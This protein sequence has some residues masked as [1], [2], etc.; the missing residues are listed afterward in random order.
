MLMV[1]WVQ[2]TLMPIHG[3]MGIIA[4][5]ERW[6][7]VFW[8]KLIMKHHSKSTLSQ[9]EFPENVNID[10]EAPVWH[11]SCHTRVELL[12]SYLHLPI[13]VALPGLWQTDNLFHSMDRILDNFFRHLGWHTW[14]WS[15]WI[16]SFM[17]HLHN[18]WKNAKF[19]KYIK[20]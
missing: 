14:T 8:L 11:K 3:G 4:R 16:F 15:V 17:K 7:K 20:I 6:E 5:E 1:T 13:K 12:C 18:R 2:Q 10:Q 9:S 19:Q